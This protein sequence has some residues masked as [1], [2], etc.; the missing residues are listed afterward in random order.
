MNEKYSSD[1]LKPLW[2]AVAALF[3]V[4]TF[5]IML[6]ILCAIML[7][8]WPIIPILAYYQRKEELKDNDCIK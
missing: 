5:V 4:P 1:N 7:C 2:Y 3:S 8:I 6:L